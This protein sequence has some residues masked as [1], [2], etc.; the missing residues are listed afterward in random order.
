MQRVNL[1]I[2]LSPVSYLKHSSSPLLSAV[3]FLNLGD[4]IYKVYHK[5]FL[6]GSVPLHTLEQFICKITLGIVC[7]LTADTICGRSKYDD[8]AALTNMAAH[9]PAGT[10]TK[11]LVHYEQWIQK[12]V[13]Q[14][15]DYGRKGPAPVPY[16]LT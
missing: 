1:V 9:F 4:L 12:D 16:D 13:F 5:G 2:A 7:S 6:D 15:F 11:D 3:S 14:T 8:D 10:S